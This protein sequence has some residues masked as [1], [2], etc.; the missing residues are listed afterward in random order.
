MA[1]ENE[2]FK[3]RFSFSGTNMTAEDGKNVI[4]NNIA[5]SAIDKNV[6]SAEDFILEDNNLSIYPNPA[7]DRIYISSNTAIDKI[8]VYNIFG[9]MMYKS[10]KKDNSIIVD[11]SNFAKGIYLVKVFSK[12]EITTKKIIK[13]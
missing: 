5:V 7:K 3:V 4:I 11:I 13:K 2:S 12:N 1:D 6:L 10:S 8:L 9:Q